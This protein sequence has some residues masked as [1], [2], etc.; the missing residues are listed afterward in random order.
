MQVTIS[1]SAGLRND[2]LLAIPREEL[3]TV[4]FHIINRDGFMGLPGLLRGTEKQDAGERAAVGKLKRPVE[5]HLHAMAGVV[6]ETGRPLRRL[7]AIGSRN[8]GNNRGFQA[9]Q[10]G[11]TPQRFLIR[12]DTPWDRPVPMLA[13]TR[14]QGLEARDLRLSERTVFE[15]CRD[16]TEEIEWCVFANCVLRRGRAIPVEEMADQF[17]D[18]AHLAAAD[19][20]TE[21]GKQI[22]EALYHGFDLRPRGEIVAAL[23][24]LRVPRNRYLHNAVGLAPARVTLLQREGTVEEMAQWLREAGAED[25]FILDNG[26]SVFCWAWWIGEKGGYL[27]RA[28]DFREPSSAVLAFLLRGAPYTDLPPGSVSYS[29]A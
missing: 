6:D 14:G 5:E 24:R 4:R 7:I 17:Y 26:G 2:L 29:A 20:G 9:W 3:E 25:G 21:R 15:E 8:V 11:L 16:I 28:P 12:G 1:K 19:R 10:R 27:F 22:W 18:M 23:R 13:L